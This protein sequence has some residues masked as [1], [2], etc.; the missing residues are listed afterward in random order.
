M[1]KVVDCF[2][3]GQYTVLILDSPPPAEWSKFVRIENTEYETEIAYDFPNAIC[4][5]E[6]G[7]FS[8]KDVEFI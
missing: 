5:K 2:T 3:A 6:K 4:V 1:R 7:N 8:N